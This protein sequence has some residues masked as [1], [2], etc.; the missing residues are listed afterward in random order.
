LTAATTALDASGF[1]NDD[2]VWR[3]LRCRIVV[4]SRKHFTTH[5][6][7]HGVSSARARSIEA[8]RVRLATFGCSSA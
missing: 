4:T 7:T 1:R 3:C 8:D 2:V 5:L 6:R